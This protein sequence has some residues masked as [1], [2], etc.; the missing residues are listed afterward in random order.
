MSNIREQL[1]EQMAIHG[2]KTG[3]ARMLIML[4][5]SNPTATLTAWNAVFPNEQIA[6]SEMLMEARVLE[7]TKTY[8][9]RKIL[10]IKDI[11]SEFNISIKEAKDFVEVILNK[12]GY[13]T[14]DQCTY[15]TTVNHP[16]S[17]L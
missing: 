2:T 16:D 5:D 10:I 4:F 8:N 13:T 14:T 3:Y 17:I 9:G 6:T 11:R 1:L 7:L 12:Y 15:V